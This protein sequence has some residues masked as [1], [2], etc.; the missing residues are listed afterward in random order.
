MR[1]VLDTVRRLAALLGPDRR[2]RWALLIAMAL[3]TTAIEIVGASAIYALLA[4]LDPG[5]VGVVGAAGP[6]GPFIP[7]AETDALRV[8]LA[9]AVVLFFVA[10]AVLH[11]GR[12]YLEGRI[13]ASAG[14][15]LSERML[16][17]YVALPYLFHTRRSSA[18]LI[19]NAFASTQAVQNG[20]LGPL[21]LLIAE[22]VL[23]LGLAGLLIAT[24]PLAAGLAALLLGTTITIIQR[25]LR[26]RLL[27]WGRLAQQASTGS[28]DTIQQA[29]GGIRDIKL[30][31]RE[32]AF[33]ADHARH[34]RRLARSAYLSTAAKVVP[35]S[36]IELGMVLTV[37]TVFLVATASGGAGPETLSTLG[38]FAYAGI[39]LQPS[40][41][42]IVGA[43]NGLRYNGAL[44]DDLVADDR[45]IRASGMNRS[46][47]DVGRV[48]A[49][50]VDRI[51]LRGV[52]L[53]Y[54][55]D[56][57]AV[58]P[59]LR[60][61]DLV[62]EPGEFL[63]ICG[64]TGGGKSTLLD[65]LVGLLP[66]TVGEVLVDGTPLGPRP[67]WW[68]RRLGVVSQA[69]FLTD[70]TLRRNI[71]FGVARDEVDEARLAR[72]LAQAQLTELVA[73]LPEGL[74]TVVGERGIRLSGGQR[75]RVAIARALYRDPPV[76]VLDEGTSAL[77]GAT[78]A[79]VIRALEDR[80]DGRTLIAVAHRLQTIR[81]ADRIVV[82]A[83]GRV[84]A[85]GTWDDLMASSGL[86]RHLAGAA[87][88]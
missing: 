51:E 29:L 28:L 26:P 15:E 56:D 66:P 47:D 38:L 62:V 53:D 33:V 41:Q 74:E 55:P 16:A 3:A 65:V 13:I 30:L 10:R 70:D 75:Q 44:A 82:M 31:G 73:G 45:L 12:A 40:L 21:V 37:V 48:D 58:R 32:A 23:V 19:R 76:L 7:A 67:T 36:L 6:L 18:D 88:G 24:A 35:R 5:T 61:V 1:D 49:A 25:T 43:I 14:V 52:E 20:V 8:T 79:A 50:G 71:A 64:P 27:I 39:R 9:L 17:G 72:C 80:E 11:V 54:V 4:V 84:A 68:W 86:F 81:H 34:R 87:A 59:A 57:P 46:T 85:E 78:E 2:W 77:D 63:G 60:G 42:M 22:G 83:E 69:V